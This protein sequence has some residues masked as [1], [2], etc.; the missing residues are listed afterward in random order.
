MSTLFDGATIVV[1]VAFTSTPLT[2]NAT[3]TA[4]SGWTD[5]TGYVRN[6][7]INRGRQTELSDYSPGTLTMALDNR[8]RTFDPSYGGN[9]APYLGNL[10]PMRKVRVRATSG[11]TT[12]T[13]FTGHIMGWPIDFPGMLDSEVNVT[14]VDGF[15]VLQ[16]IAPP[17]NAYDASVRADSPNCYWTIDT[18][19]DGAISPA[20]IGGVD[21][22]NFNNGDIAFP[23]PTPV[24][25]ITPVGPTQTLS[26]VGWAANGVPTVA[27]K[28][29]EGWFTN[30][31]Y[32][33]Y[34]GTNVAR[35]A[36]NSTNWIRLAVGAT[37]GTVSVGYSNSSGAGSSYSYASTG[38]Q[39][40]TLSV[41]LVLTVTASDLVLYANGAE[42]WR[43]PLAVGTSTNTFPSLPPPS[44]QAVCQPRAGSPVNPAIYGLAVYGSGFTATQVFTH[45]SAGL[46]GWGHPLGDR[47]GT[48]IGRI[49]TAIG[50]PS[51]DT[52]LGT[53]STVLGAY[54]PAGTALASCQDCSTAEQALFFMSAD[55]KVT[56]RDRQWQMTNSTS[57]TPQA[58]IGDSAGETSYVDIEIDG[59]H[60]DNIRNV[61]TVTYGAGSVIVKDST[62]ISDYGEQ[63]DQVSTAALP[64]EAGFVARQ[65]GAARLR[66]R[67]DATTRVPKLQITPRGGTTTVLPVI[68]DLELGKRVTVKRRQTGASYPF[69]QDCIIQGINHAITP[70][71]WMTTLYLSPVQVTAYSS[72]PW[73][74]LGDAT[75][76][77]IGSAANNKIPY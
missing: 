53:G 77:R 50:W 46:T 47:A 64:N 21:I 29:I 65:L 42:V 18:I 63:S 10:K 20:T 35:A 32:G 15:R 38:W 68:L 34:A 41:H 31:Q 39:I 44:V 70:S 2:S 52:D 8:A 19:D 28:T 75:Y 72:A 36:L 12:A 66:I 71:T 3:I 25:I 40:A 73:L 13:L 67:K 61:V 76:G 43:K 17:P 57:I 5:I 6:I 22:A 23:K 51:T 69:S 7:R 62:S 11:A 16:Q 56:M 33:V 59:N 55:G 4:A 58:T 48:R 30:L 26:N 54:N 60:L 37:D 27:P 45:Y 1:E 24:D 49:L 14:A 9:V 74:T